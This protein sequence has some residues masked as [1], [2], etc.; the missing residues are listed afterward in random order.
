MKLFIATAV[1]L[2]AVIG[3]SA[4]PA[5]CKAPAAVSN[6]QEFSKV[7]T[8]FDTNLSI[9]ILRCVRAH[10]EGFGHNAVVVLQFRIR[11]EGANPAGSPP[12]AKDKFWPRDIKARDPVLGQSFKVWENNDENDTSSK[13]FWSSEWKNGQTG[14]GYVWL[15]VPE[16]CNTIDVFFPYT[17]PIRVNVEVPK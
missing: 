10:V 9:Q 16:R 11:K 12:F 4:T 6:K 15:K 5:Y 14:D 1:M 2:C 3:L 8:G 13:A 17:N 7:M